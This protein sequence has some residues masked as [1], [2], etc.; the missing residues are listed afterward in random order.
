VGDFVPADRATAAE[1][2]TAPRE[3][4]L[5]AARDP[6]EPSGRNR[7]IRGTTAFVALMVVC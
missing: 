5:S 3:T 7:E 4:G 6:F 1:P 2:V